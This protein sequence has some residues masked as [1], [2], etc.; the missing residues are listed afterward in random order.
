MV[1][2]STLAG[3]FI[4]REGETEPSE[5]LFCNVLSILKC[6]KRFFLLHMKKLRHVEGMICR[7]ARDLVTISDPQAMPA[8]GLLACSLP[9]CGSWATV[10]GQKRCVDP[11]EHENLVWEARRVSEHR[12][13]LFC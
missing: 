13:R 3:V 4:Q 9:C 7:G 6:R 8:D 2:D 12:H 5:C 10:G 11:S 1:F